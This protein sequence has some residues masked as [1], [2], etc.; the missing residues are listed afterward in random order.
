MSET[1]GQSG[2]W[3]PLILPYGPLS[4]L[5]PRCCVPLSAVWELPDKCPQGGITRGQRTRCA[6]LPT[7]TRSTAT[8]G[9]Q[10]GKGSD[11]SYRKPL[12]FWWE[13]ASFIPKARATH[14][15]CYC[16]ILQGFSVRPMLP[17]I[18]HWARSPGI[19]QLSE[20]RGDWDSFSTPFA[21]D[22][23]SVCSSV[24]TWG[25]FFASKNP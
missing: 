21:S 2:C 22:G 13:W 8:D 6:E 24:T 10:E 15:H 4:T 17:S 25:Y 16:V 5:S 9:A 1:A 14:L 11:R 12:R 19:I 18:Y 7:S 23:Y 3:D 20:M